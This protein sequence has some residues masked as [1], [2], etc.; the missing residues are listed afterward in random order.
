MTSTAL[1]VVLCAIALLLLAISFFRP[2]SSEHRLQLQVTAAVVAFGVLLQLGIGTMRD[3]SR[4]RSARIELELIQPEDNS[5]VERRQIAKG[6]FTP[7]NGVVVV[8]VKPL[9]T[10]ELWIQDPPVLGN[11]GQ[12]ETLCYFGDDKYGA[13][14]RFQLIVFGYADHNIVRGHQ[15]TA[16]RKLITFEELPPPDRREVRTV[17]RTK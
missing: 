7:S 6:Q 5:L 3:A 14:E 11:N 8:L 17:T 1:S 13:G 10:G 2:V 4:S 12:W 15:L 9:S 16:G